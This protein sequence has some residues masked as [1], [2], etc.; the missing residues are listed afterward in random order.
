MVRIGLEWRTPFGSLPLNTVPVRFD[1]WIGLDALGD[2][3][4]APTGWVPG[5]HVEVD[6]ITHNGLTGR[7]AGFSVGNGQCPPLGESFDLAVRPVAGAW[8]CQCP[9]YAARQ[10][11][12][13]SVA[14]QSAAACYWC[15]HVG[16]DVETYRNGWAGGEPIALCAACFAPKEAGR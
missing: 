9:G 15:N 5:E 16:A 2:A 1:L 8:Q 13:H 6:F 3:G 10:A 12:C 4:R 14:A 7:K 11:C